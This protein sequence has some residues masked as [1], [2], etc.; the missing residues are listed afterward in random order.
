MSLIV[1]LVLVD[2]AL[3]VGSIFGKIP[4]WAVDFAICV[5]LLV[6]FWSH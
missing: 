5:T 6:A 3:C 2:L 4:G 1:V